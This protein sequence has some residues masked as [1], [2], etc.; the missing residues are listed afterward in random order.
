MLVA[1]EVDVLDAHLRSLVDIEVD[2][3][4]VA[5]HRVFLS[6]D[7]HIAEKVAFLGVVALDDAY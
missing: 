5:H 6:L 7:I 3:D 2:L 1:Y 4:G